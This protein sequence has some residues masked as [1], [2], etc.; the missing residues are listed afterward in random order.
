MV[1]M[2]A[3]LATS[4]LA[5]SVA[6]APAAAQ[7]WPAKPIRWIIDFPAGGVSDV[8]ARTVGA[9]LG[10]RL[11]QTIVY[12]NR[13][14]ANGVIANDYC[15][16]AAPDGYT[17]CFLSQPFSLQF[18]L[19][20]KLPFTLADFAPVALLAQY[21]SLLVVNPSV[22]AQNVREFVGWVKTKSPP[23]SYASSG[24]GGAQHLAMERFRRA[25]GY[26]ALHVPYS[27]SAPGLLDVIGGRV[28][29]IFVNVT[30]ALP[31][32]RAG[33]IRALALAGPSRS[34]LLPDVPTFAETGYP[35]EALG[36]AGAA[37][38]AAVPREI[39]T[40]LNAELVSVM[41]TPEMRERIVSL[42]AEARWSTPEEFGVAIREDIQRWAPT[43]RESGATTQN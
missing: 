35:F 10:E 30:G 13:P 5:A 33:K 39:V 6:P 28:E 40:R 26:E 25:A 16:K 9:K 38:Q 42:G 8:L 27:G 37:Y 32:L 34:P 12:E 18:T 15:A 1:T 21:P 23:V 20:P 36:W 29:S 41:K 31:H 22:P 14:G 4:A 17:L 43:I 19:N 24:A 3:T 2:I 7:A 11:G